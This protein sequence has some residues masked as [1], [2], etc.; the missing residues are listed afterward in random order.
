[1]VSVQTCAVLALTV[2]DGCLFTTVMNDVAKG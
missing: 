1:M 2:S